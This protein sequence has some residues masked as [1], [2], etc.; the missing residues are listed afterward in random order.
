MVF[1]KSELLNNHMSGHKTISSNQRGCFFLMRL[2]FFALKHQFKCKT[3]ESYIFQVNTDKNCAL[4]TEG[5][6]YCF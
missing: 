4:I 5:K 1:T 2:V 6:G 3:S